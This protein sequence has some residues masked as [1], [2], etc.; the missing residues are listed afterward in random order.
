MSSPLKGRYNK[1]QVF[2][3]A[4]CDVSGTKNRL[5]QLPTNFT[6]RHETVYVQP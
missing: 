6:R 3:S 5:K 4:E 2:S 1:D